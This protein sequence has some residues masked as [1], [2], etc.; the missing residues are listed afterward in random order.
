MR[1]QLKLASAAL[2]L[3]FGFANFAIAEVTQTS[4]TSSDWARE[5]KKAKSACA[6]VESGG[7]IDTYSACTK[8]QCYTIS[9]SSEQPNRNCIAEQSPN[10]LLG[11]KNRLA[12]TRLL[13][14]GVLPNRSQSA[15]GGAS[16]VGGGSQGT[17]GA[18]NVGGAVH[19][20]PSRDGGSSCSGGV[21]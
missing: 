7:G 11:T 10:R 18:S 3:G 12:V 2:L 5:C 21:C 14:P 9:C 13:G 4:G 19:G 8:S 20:G 15:N 1:Y 16:Q 6:L 17:N